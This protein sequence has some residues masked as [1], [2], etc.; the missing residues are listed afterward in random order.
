MR[1]M[2]VIIT[3][4]AISFCILPFPQRSHGRAH[5]SPLHSHSNLVRRLRQGES[6]SFS[7]TLSVDS[8]WDVASSSP[9]LS[10]TVLTP[11]L[12]WKQ[13]DNW[14]LISRGDSICNVQDMLVAFLFSIEICSESKSS[15]CLLWS[16]CS[17]VLLSSLPHKFHFYGTY[18]DGNGHVILVLCIIGPSPPLAHL[19]LHYALQKNHNPDHLR[20]NHAPEMNSRLTQGKRLALQVLAQCHLPVRPLPAQRYVCGPPSP[21]GPVLLVCDSGT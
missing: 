20:Q 18:K 9:L 11:L 17:T 10:L 3:S 14:L 4:A 8:N 12:S 16:M 19:A 1:M 6:P 15:F 21:A 2:T 5:G 13:G 7:F